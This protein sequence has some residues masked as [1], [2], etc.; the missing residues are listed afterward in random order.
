MAEQPWYWRGL[1]SALLSPASWAWKAGQGLRNRRRRLEPHE[2][3][4]I[5]VGNP[6]V[7]GSGKTPISIDLVQRARRSGYETCWLGRGV[8]GDGRIRQVTQET[9]ASQV[10]DE[11]L[12]ARHHLGAHCYAGVPRSAV[13]RMAH[14]HGCQ[15]AVS[16]DGMQSPDLRPDRL[17]VCLR[18]EDPWGNGRIL[19]AG[20]LREGPACLARADLIVWHGLDNGPLELP[21][22]ADERW[23]RA[24]YDVVVPELPED[25]PVGVA[26]AIADPYRLV[27]TVEA[28]GLEI[29]RVITAP[30]HGIL[31]LRQLDPHMTWLTS[32]KDL[33]RMAGGLPENLDIRVVEANLVWGDGGKRVEAMLSELASQGTESA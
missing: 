3:P 28:A 12:L 22:E 24:W 26:T 16:D 17:V 8:G 21:A 20:P 18:A 30:D 6:R 2:L 29:Q 1:P 27:R 11:A 19:P 31:P 10:G 4:L 13:I 23:L 32:S 5:V 25:R 7:G 33:A 14:R 9:G 15:L